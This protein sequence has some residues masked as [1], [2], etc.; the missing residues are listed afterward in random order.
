MLALAER[1]EE[2]TN[3]SLQKRRIFCLFMIQFQNRVFDIWDSNSV[4]LILICH[5]FQGI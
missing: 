3:P 4:L 2:R 5:Q 1:K